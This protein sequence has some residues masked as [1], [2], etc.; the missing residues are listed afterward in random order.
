MSG[1]PLRDHFRDGDARDVASHAKH[2]EAQRRYQH[3]RLQMLGNQTEECHRHFYV[4][5]RRDIA[6]GKPVDGRASKHHARS[7][8]SREANAAL[9]E[10]DA[11]EEQH[12]QEDVENAIG[13]GI[14]AVFACCPSHSAFFKRGF[15]RC[16]KWRHDVPKHVAHHH[17]KRHDDEHAPTFHT[18]IGF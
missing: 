1:E 15:Q 4:C 3:L 18:S 9:V 14:E 6:Q 17:G 7:E 10:N 16:G 2:A 12:Q 8:Q 5:R 13:T 11:T